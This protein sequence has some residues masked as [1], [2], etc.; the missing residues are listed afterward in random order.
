MAS[1]AVVPSATAGYG[2]NVEGIDE[3]DAF[4]FAIEVPAA[5]GGGGQKTLK[6]TL[7]WTDSAGAQLQSDLDLVVRLEGEGEG[8]ERHGNMGTGAGFD[9]VNNVEQ[10]KWEGLAAGSRVV[11]E[12]RVFR[13]TGERQGFAWAWKLE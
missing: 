2:E 1:S 8:Q 7:V 4:S 10:V 5:E 9:R 13:L 6:V 12:V 11:V 3:D